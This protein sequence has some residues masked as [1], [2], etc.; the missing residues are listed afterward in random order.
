MKKQRNKA[1]KPMMSREN[2]PFDS[3]DRTEIN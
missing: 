3:G 2:K 1:S